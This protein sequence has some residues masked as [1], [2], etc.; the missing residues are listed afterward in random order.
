[1]KILSAVMPAYWPS[2]Q[3]FWQAAQCQTIILTDHFQYTKRSCST[4]SALLHSA[5]PALRLPVR[6]LDPAASIA[7]KQFDPNSLWRKK[8]LQTIHH[9]FHNTPY[10]YYYLPAI[11]ELLS[12]EENSLSDFL[13]ATT[14]QIL[15]WLHFENE[16]NQSS[17]L[18]HSGSHESLLQNWCDH[19]RCDTCLTE[20]I[21]LDK[22]MIN[23]KA[24]EKTGIRCRSFTPFP[25]YHILQSNRNLSI[26]NFLMDYG[27]EAGYLIR[28]YLSS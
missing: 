16:L 7:E 24:L 25:E 8:H 14:K 27:P 5:Q 19:F 11:E 9:L 22:G 20:T 26:L 12:A 13:Y 28:Q 3:F 15:N 10:A 6:H 4:S 23:Q 1:M 21:H 17:K 2:L 18:P